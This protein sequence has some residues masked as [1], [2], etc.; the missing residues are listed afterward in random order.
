MPRP[1]PV[2]PAWRAVYRLQL[3]PGF[4]FD[5]AAAQVDYLA[6]L[7]VSHVYCSPIL[8]AGSDHGYD[9][10]DHG[11][12]REA[13]GGR[14]GFER[15]VAA[16]RAAGLGVLVDIVPNHM[17]IGGQT[18][19][20]R[21][22]W[23][24]LEHGRAS[25][26]AGAFDIVWDEIPDGR[27][28][29]PLL[30]DHLHRVIAAGRLRPVRAPDG[31]LQLTFETQRFPLSPGSSAPLLARAADRAGDSVLAALAGQL[32]AA[33]DHPADD[34]TTARDRRDGVDRLTAATRAHLAERPDVAAA[35][36][37]VLDEV[38]GDPDALAELAAHQHYRL[39]RWRIANR[40]IGYRRF[41]DVTELVALR[42]DV[43]WV[44]DATHALV[45]DLVEAGLVDG[46]R[47]DH[48]DGLR[49]PQAY[50][51]RLHGRAGPTPLWVEKIL[52]PGE[53]LRPSWATAGTTGYDFLDVAGRL[54]V[55]TTGA[56]E[57]QQWFVAGTGVP[58]R[59]DDAARGAKHEVLG[60][61][62][63]ADLDRLAA[64]AAR[65]LDGAGWDVSGREMR[66]ALAELIA[67]LPVYRT[68]VRPGH[69]PDPADAGLLHDAVD[70][71]AARRRDLEHDVL[72]VLRDTLLHP[73][74]DD[75]AD[76]V[77]RFQQLSSAAAAKGVE[78]TTFYRWAP[79]T[80]L[81]EV[82]SHP[83]A[84]GVDAA[85]FHAAVRAAA[86]WPHRLLETSTHDTKRSEDV[87]ARINVLSEVPDRWRAAV[88]EVRA[89]A[90]TPGAAG[91]PVLE[92][93]VL[94]TAVGAWPIDGDRL[95]AYAL[96]AAR[97]AK[98]RTDWLDP[99]EAYEANLQAWAR[100]LVDDPA[101][102]APLDGLVDE[103]RWPGQVNALAQVVLKIAAPGVAGLYQGTELWDGSLV[104]PDNRRPVDLDRRRDLLAALAE[105]D[106]AAARARADDGGLKLWVVARALRVRAERADSLDGAAP[107]VPLDPVGPA[108]GH[109]VAFAR[110]DDVVAVVPRLVVGLGR[111]G[112]WRDTVV[113]LPPGTW[114]DALGDGRPWTGELRLADAL[115][116]VPVALL[117][118]G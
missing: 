67:A 43:P 27:L 42:V 75:E 118:R 1:T 84:E 3:R 48:P 25:P 94:Q 63:A 28:L 62:L 55:D 45:L 34:P 60:G 14:A 19:G 78:D 20:N 73:S 101:C 12:V 16:A 58:P 38:A 69:P 26:Y 33:A 50:L 112:G 8:E 113:P 95:A 114:V 85:G 83:D 89:A 23:D 91:D 44:F 51:D 65:A 115:D 41:F 107:Y 54:A 46:L 61:L 90:P 56:R 18:A 53:A 57:L 9:V 35:V 80:S 104:D 17:A 4:T 22:W 98:R 97:E 30:D 70:E 106:D 15:L 87:R 47:I 76:L 109:A 110:S 74:S 52:A 88:A 39:A 37:A 24:V 96:K 108:A 103:I 21:W 111:A 68:Y 36:D 13:L 2:G 100:A 7:G 49:D 105:A 32:A 59:L 66:E 5:D 93:L 31:A 92:L 11:R 10:V 64:L 6:A 82:G 72:R 99:D 102:R 81:C 117:V 79:L 86:G 77:E 71:V 116:P 29:V 40:E